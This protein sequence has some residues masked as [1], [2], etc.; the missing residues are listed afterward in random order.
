MIYRRNLTPLRS[1]L[2]P[3]AISIFCLSQHQI[4]RQ[5]FFPSLHTDAGRGPGPPPVYSS[6]R[7]PSKVVADP[8][9]RGAGP[10]SHTAT[11]AGAPPPDV[12]P[13]PV[14]HPPAALLSPP[15]DLL[16]PPSSHEYCD[17]ELYHFLEFCA[18]SEAAY[19]HHCPVPSSRHVSMAAIIVN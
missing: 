6:R 12:G 11:R 4:H 14:V 7:R 2:E 3:A 1:L 15:P 5:P 8:S 9:P 13:P 19:L 17:N 18:P 10:S 16:A